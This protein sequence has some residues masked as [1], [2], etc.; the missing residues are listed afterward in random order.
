VGYC[1]AW[2]AAATDELW[3]AEPPEGALLPDHA[4][5]RGV[6]A[7]LRECWNHLNTNI[8]AQPTAFVRQPMI[9]LTVTLANQILGL[10]DTLSFTRSEA[11]TDLQTLAD[12]T[13][14]VAAQFEQAVTGN[15]DVGE[16][17]NA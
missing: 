3:E 13:A 1:I 16:G 7:D 11:L 2:T 12:N 8:N 10:I 6:T 17:R 5:R 4:T 15:R 14:Y 9:D